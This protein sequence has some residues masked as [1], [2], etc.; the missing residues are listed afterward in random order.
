MPVAGRENRHFARLESQY[1]PCRVISVESDVPLLVIGLRERQKRSL[2]DLNLLLPRNHDLDI[3]IA[4]VRLKNAIARTRRVDLRN[5][6][7]PA[8]QILPLALSLFKREELRS[9]LTR[10]TK[11]AINIG[12]RS[13]KARPTNR[14]RTHSIEGTKYGHC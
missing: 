10:F 1:A 5:S 3:V 7:G 13:H 12:K 4:A 8:L 14:L 2:C 11:Q 9:P 6:K